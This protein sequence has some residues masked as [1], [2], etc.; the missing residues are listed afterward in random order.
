MYAPSKHL[1][2]IVKRSSTFLLLLLTLGLSSIALASGGSHYSGSSGKPKLDSV[3]YALGKQVY[4]NH[5]NCDNC[6]IN[7]SKVSKPEALSLYKQ[8]KKNKNLKQSL[9]K[10]ERK[11]LKYYMRERF[12][13]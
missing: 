6:L 10:K 8:I 12:K 13:L 3:R 2:P 1:T 4:K 9:S 5:I 11:A 7:Q